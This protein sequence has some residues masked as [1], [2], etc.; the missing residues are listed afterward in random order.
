MKEHM[1]TY[2]KPLLLAAILLTANSCQRPNDA[3]K[4]AVYNGVEELVSAAVNQIEQISIEDFKKL[5]EAQDM[6]ILLDVRSESEHD[7][8]YIPGSVNIPRGLLEFWIEKEAFWEDEGMYSP[9]KEDILV[10]Y[11][12]SGKRSALS[13]KTLK[14][15]GFDKVYS[16]DGGFDAWKAAFPDEVLDN[17]PIIEVPGNTGEVKIPASSGGC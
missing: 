3:I 7:F 17:Q 4:L 10:V 1:R 9:L 13:T 11:C 16:L 2:I 12:K 15:L 6:Y 14:Q 8:G 5:V